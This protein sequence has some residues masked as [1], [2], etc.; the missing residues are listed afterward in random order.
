MRKIIFPFCLLFFFSLFSGTDAKAGEIPK[1]IL[2]QD[3]LRDASGAPVNG[4][5]Y[6]TFSLYE[7][8]VGDAPLWNETQAVEIHDGLYEVLLGAVVPL[9]LPFDAPYYLGIRT[10]D[11]PEMIPR[12]PLHSAGY[13]FSAARAETVADGKI[14]DIGISETAGISTLKLSGPVTDIPDHGLGFLAL[15][16][17]VT[18][19]DI[20]QN[21]CSAGQVIRR[22]PDNSKWECGNSDGRI[23]ALS[24]SEAKSFSMTSSRSVDEEELIS[25]SR[26]AETSILQEAVSGE[27]IAPADLYA[28][29]GV[30]LSNRLILNSNI[31]DSSSTPSFQILNTDTTDT[32]TTPN[33]PI[34]E[35]L[36]GGGLVAKGVIGA[37]SMPA[38]GCGYRMMWHPFK[39]AFRAGGT[40][41]GGACNYWDDANMGFY[42]WAGGNLTKAAA[43]GTFAFGDQVTVTGV[44]GAAFGASNTV[45]GTVGFSTG[46][47][48]TC[49]GFGCVAMG[50]TNFAQGQGAVA[51]GYRTGACSN[52]STALGQRVT[53]ESGL[54]GLTGNPCT[55]GA[56]K[57]GAF[58]WGDNST[59]TFMAA[60]FDN[61]FRIRAAGGVRLRTSSAASAAAGLSGNTGCDLATGSGNW[62]CSSSRSI[63]ENFSPVNGQ[64]ILDRISALPISTWNFISG[65]PDVRHIGPVAEDFYEAF[66]LGE[67]N[68]SIGVQDLAGVNMAAIK[69]LI[70]ENDEL[71]AELSEIKNRME[72]MEKLFSISA[73]ITDR[74]VF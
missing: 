12:Q 55:G 72:R 21:G 66:S 59:T 49:S 38:S 45:S 43:F 50:Y 25:R 2:F 18:L 57:I 15:K 71:K 73:G 26:V 11:G 39:A 74:T 14:T 30:T 31:N 52:Y 47:Y 62:S 44:D 40:D 16:N 65:D 68:A 17:T 13:A 7:A 42:S 27:P 20:D 28:A 32:H 53:T 58:V 6:L 29:D 54:A 60:Q 10:G 4:R 3:S 34:F 36:P 5:F 48:N 56:S 63:K 37:G 33:Y 1:T 64:Q 67:G 23:P 51:I 46:A 24:I 41:D 61:E 35:V 69:E 9:S 19:S 70:R 8:P 22:S